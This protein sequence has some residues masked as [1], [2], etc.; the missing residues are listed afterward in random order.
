MKKIVTAILSFLLLIL[1]LVL[2][3][4]DLE[5]ENPKL[6][7]I[8]PENDVREI[9][10]EEG[11]TFSCSENYY[12]GQEGVTG[13]FSYRI[14]WDN[15]GKNMDLTI[16]C[17]EEI[18]YIEILSYKGIIGREE[19]KSKEFVLGRQYNGQIFDSFILYITIEGVQYQ[20]R[21]YLVGVG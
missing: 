14:N 20:A 16:S 10:T 12:L 1:P 6:H 17:N 5:S 13:Q 21:F 9:S 3:G 19:V 11:V 8:R 18:D 2:T 15:P 4:C 7:L